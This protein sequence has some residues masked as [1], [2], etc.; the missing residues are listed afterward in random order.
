LNIGKEGLAH[1]WITEILSKLNMRTIIL[2][3]HVAR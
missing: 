3:A 1:A 2:A